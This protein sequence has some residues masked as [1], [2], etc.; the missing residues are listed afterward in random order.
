MRGGQRRSSNAFGV[1]AQWVDAIVVNRLIAFF[2]PRVIGKSRTG[3]IAADHTMA[4]AV[5]AAAVAVAVDIPRA[6]CLRRRLQRRV[7]RRTPRIVADPVL[8]FP[9]R[10]PP[11]DH[12]RRRCHA[13]LQPQRLCIRAMEAVAA[14]VAILRIALALRSFVA[15]RHRLRPRLYVSALGRCVAPDF[16]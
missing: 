6:R 3:E 4:V 16:D 2:V 13:P 8:L 9:L 11:C 15:V 10:P 7:P 14:V 12:D 5:A 1:G